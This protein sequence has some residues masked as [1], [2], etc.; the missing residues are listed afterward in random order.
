MSSAPASQAAC[1]SNYYFEYQH[2]TYCSAESAELGQCA[3]HP[4]VDVIA[5]VSAGD[6]VEDLVGHGLV[7]PALHKAAPRH[8]HACDLTTLLLSWQH[9]MFAAVAPV[10]APVAAAAAAT[11]SLD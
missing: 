9:N 6:V 7:V 3:I 4:Q 11:P 5:R 1:N 10:A 2:L 8:V